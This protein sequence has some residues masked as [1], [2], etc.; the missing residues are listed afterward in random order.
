MNKKNICISF[1]G[2]R[3]ALSLSIAICFHLQGASTLWDYGL[4]GFIQSRYGEKYGVKATQALFGGKEEERSSEPGF[5]ERILGSGGSNV[6]AWAGGA[7]LGAAVDSFRPSFFGA[8][9]NDSTG[10]QVISAIGSGVGSSVGSELAKSAAGWLMFKAPVAKATQEQAGQDSGKQAQTGSWQDYVVPIASLGGG[11]AGSYFGGA[12]SN[13]AL[14]KTMSWLSQRS[15]WAKSHAG[16][17]T[18]LLAAGTVATL[19]GIAKASECVAPQEEGASDAKG[20]SATSPVAAQQAAPKSTPQTVLQQALAASAIAR[21]KTSESNAKE[22]YKDVVAK[23]GLSNA[24]RSA[25]DLAK[26]AWQGAVAKDLTPKE[27]EAVGNMIA[28][29][30]LELNTIAQAESKEIPKELFNMESSADRMMQA[31]DK[32]AKAVQALTESFADRERDRQKSLEDYLKT[33]NLRLAR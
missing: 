23:E 20:A 9:S 28:A 24:P 2:K 6:G 17:T 21:G 29:R 5:A 33:N 13:K 15:D 10:T 22:F 12:A 26:D 31:T 1:K 30:E 27:N 8:S 14:N 7:L 25:V 4:K 3:L 11:F 16:L 19:C 18:A 32:L